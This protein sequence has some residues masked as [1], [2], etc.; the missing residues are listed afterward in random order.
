[1][2]E[3]T[4][5]TII[6]VRRPRPELTGDTR[7]RLSQI[8]DLAAWIEDRRYGIGEISQTT[9]LMKTPDGWVV[10]P[11]SMAPGV[12]KTIEST[13]RNGGGGKRGKPNSR[14]KQKSIA[15]RKFE[16]NHKQTEAGNRAPENNTPR[17]RSPIKVQQNIPVTGNGRPDGKKIGTLLKG[18]K[19]KNV[20]SMARGKGIDCL[21]R[22]QNTYKKSDPEKWSKNE[23]VG[24]VQLKNR[25]LNMKLHYYCYDDKEIY[26]QKPR[27]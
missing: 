9:G 26:E 12:G 8:K 13:H 19:L 11:H 25:T 15:Q 22:L 17:R 27:L 1:M 7:I 5:D 24:Q 4:A 23:A 16:Q 14:K 20:I 21:Q 18:Q 10:P 3:L 2:R 6:R